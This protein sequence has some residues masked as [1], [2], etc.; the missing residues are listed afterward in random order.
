MGA[1]ARHGKHQVAGSARDLK[2]SSAV[3][4][5]SVLTS[6]HWHLLPQLLWQGAASNP[7][8]IRDY[9]A[10]LDGNSH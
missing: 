2:C 7:K 9:R 6:Q 4:S 10:D 5:L 3:G 8:A 1:N